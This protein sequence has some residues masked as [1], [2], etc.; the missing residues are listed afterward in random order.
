MSVWLILLNTFQF[1]GYYHIRVSLSDITTYGSVWRI[2][3]F[4]WYFYLWVTLS[5]ITTNGSVWLIMSHN[6]QFDWYC[7]IRV[8][9]VLLLHTR[10]FYWCCCIPVSLTGITIIQISLIDINTYGSVWLIFHIHE[11][12]SDNSTYWSVGVILHWVWLILLHMG[13][14]DWYCYICVSL[15]DIPTYR[16]FEW[17]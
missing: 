16:K 4:E 6:N 3:Q 1:E 8:S 2:L 17:Y 10:Q 5:E 9:G 13:Q 11:S 7:Y 15:S 12:F 14:F